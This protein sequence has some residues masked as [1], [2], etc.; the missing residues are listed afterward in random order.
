ML[1]Y[2]HS[3]NSANQIKYSVN[4]YNLTNN[5]LIEK[6]RIQLNFPLE[7]S[8]VENRQKHLEK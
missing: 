4:V 3:K 1:Q 6:E 5:Y 2:L 7:D 8:F